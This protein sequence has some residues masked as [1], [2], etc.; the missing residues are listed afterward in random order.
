MRCGVGKLEESEGRPIDHLG[1]FDLLL[2][3]RAE[4]DPQQQ[5]EKSETGH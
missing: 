5:F 3:S 2:C 4:F 1:C